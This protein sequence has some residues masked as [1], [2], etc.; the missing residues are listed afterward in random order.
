M[1]VVEA[2]QVIANWIVGNRGITPATPPAGD[3]V[4]L[5]AGG[6]PLP[7]HHDTAETPLES[8]H[9]LHNRLTI[10][11]PKPELE[12]KKISFVVMG[13]D[14][15]KGQYCEFTWKNDGVDRFGD[16]HVFKLVKRIAQEMCGPVEVVDRIVVTVNN[17][18]EVCL[19]PTNAFQCILNHQ[20]NA[21]TVYK[22][23]SVGAIGL[24]YILDVAFWFI[25]CCRNQ[26]THQRTSIK[27]KIAKWIPECSVASTSNATESSSSL[28]R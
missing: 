8:P 13:F 21:I 2:A 9:T 25:A 22:K 28:D 10:P 5:E 16:A 26:F 19:S 12:G 14:S 23:Q 20:P 7:P 6:R 18:G 3:D 24:E 17:S 27:S 1:L 4:D 11:V 15:L